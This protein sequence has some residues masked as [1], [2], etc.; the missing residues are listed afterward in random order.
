M[1]RFKFIVVFLIIGT[2]S[3]LEG[4]VFVCTDKN[5][6]SYYS[7]KKCPD[8]KLKTEVYENI[9][10]ASVPTAVKKHENNIYVLKRSLTLIVERFS[11]DLDYFKAYKT[12][13]NVELKHIKTAAKVLRKTHSSYNPFNKDELTVIIGAISRSCRIDAYMTSCGI[14]ESHDWLN[15][16]EQE[17]LQKH[18]V[19]R[20]NYFVLPEIRKLNCEKA[21]RAK[22]GGVI[23]D[24]MK[25]HFC[26][27]KANE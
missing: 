16:Q 24:N 13:L 18:K 2:F 23:S 4:R 10:D 8:N 6:A 26:S 22:S 12:V 25:R 15:S 9:S 14:I 11:E 20:K 1:Y 27:G 5:G 7:D 3:H 21:E 19:S 17:Y